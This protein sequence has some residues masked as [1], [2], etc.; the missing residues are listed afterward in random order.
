VRRARWIGSGLAVAALL[1]AGMFVLC[2]PGR[3]DEAAF[4]AA[5]GQP[6]PPLAGPVAVYHLGHSLVGRDMPAMLAQLAG[7]D[8]ASQLGWGVSLREHQTGEVRGMAEENRSPAFRPV[9]EALASG[10]Y[11]VVVLT[12]MVEL[13]DAI[14]YHGSAEALAYWAKTARQANP[15][16][17]IYLYETWHRRDDPAGWLARLDADLPALWEGA[18]LRRA[19]A[20]P[21]VGVIHVI[22]GGQVMAA[23]E[24]AAAAGEIPGLAGTDALFADEIHFND[25]G[26]WL[27]ANTHY[28]VIYGRSPVGLPVAL[29]KADG[30]AATAVAPDMAR[31][32][33]EVVWRVVTSYPATGVSQAE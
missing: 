32:L 19:M 21:G 20:R 30:T 11:P 13:K 26:A 33:Q 9:D 7:H 6:L 10:D 14:R 8:H 24:R 25:L 28:A 16:V 12:E 31:A 15:A 4:A 3:L 22:P 29:R 18:L 23:V 17:R 2:R 27:M 5:Y 1:A